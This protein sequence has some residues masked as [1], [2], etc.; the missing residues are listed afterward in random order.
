MKTF[1]DN[2]CQHINGDGD[3]DL[4]LDGVFRCSVEGLDPQMLFN[5]F[6][7]Y[8]HL[9]TAFVQQSNRQRRFDEV[10]CQE[11]EFFPCQ[12]IGESYPSQGTGIILLDIEPFQ[13]NCLIENIDVVNLAGSNNDKG[14]NATV[15][16][17]Q[18]MQFDG[19]LVPAEL[20]PGKQRQAKVDGSRV[21][22]I[23]NL[24]QFLSE[25]FFGIQSDRFSNQNMSKIGEDFPWSVF[26]CAGQSASR[27][28]GTNTGVIQARA[29]GFQTCYNG[30]ETVS[31]CQLRKRHN[32]KLLVTGQFPDMI[33]SAML[34]YAFVEFV[35]W[36]PIHQLGKNR[37]SFVHLLVLLP[38]GRRKPLKNT[39]WN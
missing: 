34:F 33:I 35:L 17:Q 32:Q 5:P 1:L 26:V 37:S 21:Q 9:P 19:R 15:Q 16:I 10:V 25:F 23:G 38:Y 3:P 11:H 4:G 2:G 36:P 30:S 27:N 29:Q 18:G 20:G 39:F 13:D 28:G 8:L 31:T 6:E 7:E 24:F 14:W 22:R 12:T